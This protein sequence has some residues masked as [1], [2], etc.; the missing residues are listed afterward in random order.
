M[1]HCGRTTEKKNDEQP[2][3]RASKNDN[4]VIIMLWGGFLGRARIIPPE[5]T[6]PSTQFLPQRCEGKTLIRTTS[7]TPATLT[8]FVYLLLFLNT[9]IGLRR[10]RNFARLSIMRDE[11]VSSVLCRECVAALTLRKRIGRC[12]F[13]RSAM[14]NLVDGRVR[15]LK[16]CIPILQCIDQ[17]IN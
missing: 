3:I 4:N 17:L 16:L 15:V 10:S 9:A 7:A 8:D 12:V 6:I 14:M 11:C 5:I 1:R 2:P 13:C